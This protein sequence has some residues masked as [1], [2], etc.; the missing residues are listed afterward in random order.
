MKT[1]IKNPFPLPAVIAGLGLILA[2]RVAA[3]SPPGVTIQPTNSWVA[4]TVG[5]N[6]TFAAAVT[7][8]GP[9]SYQWRLNSNNLPNGI[10]STMA[11]SGP[12]A[13]AN[14]GYTGDGGPATNAELFYPQGVRWTPPVT[15]SLRIQ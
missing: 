14:G 1:S 7:G 15:C 10:I 13:G 2:G 9:F 3:Q 6:V 11:G 8:T 12:G 4:A 5:N